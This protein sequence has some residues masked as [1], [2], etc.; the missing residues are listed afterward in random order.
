MSQEDSPWPP[1]V[2]TRVRIKRGN[3]TGTVVKT[4]GVYE[5]RFRLLVP[6]PASAAGQ[7]APTGAARAARIASRWYGLDEL[8]PLTES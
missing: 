8:E 7:K 3:L 2:G 4:K 1:T 6:P 5:E